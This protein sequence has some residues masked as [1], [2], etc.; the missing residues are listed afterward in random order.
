[1]NL[2]WTDRRVWVSLWL[3][4]AVALSWLK[5][6]DTLAQAQAEAGLSRALAAFA[7][8]RALNAVVSVVQGTE[9]SAGFGLGVTLTPGQVLDPVNDLIEQFSTVTLWASLAFGAQVLLMKMGAFWGVSLLL[10]LVAVVCGAWLLRGKPWPRPL[11]GLLAMV[12]VLR[13]AL[14]LVSVG[15]D[16]AFQSFMA[17]GFQSSQQGLGQSAAHLGALQAGEKPLGPT[18]AA[19]GQP[20]AEGKAERNA[21]REAISPPASPRWWDVPARVQALKQA[22]DQAVNDI[23]RLAVIFC[24]QTLVLPLLMGWLLLAAARRWAGERG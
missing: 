6:L 7:T 16:L 3:A 20:G 1:M 15:S 13:F 4:L 14:P 2:R 10:S 18:G 21:E 12:L 19:S 9:V 23:I 5:P 22:A 17:E 24:V 8:A 11:K